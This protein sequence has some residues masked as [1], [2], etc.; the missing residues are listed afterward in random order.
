MKAKIKGKLNKITALLIVVLSMLSL[1]ACSF[2][3]NTGGVDDS[4]I[5][6]VYTENIIEAN[7]TVILELYDTNG[8]GMVTARASS[9]GSGVVFK[10]NKIA[11]NIK[12][13]YLLLTNNHVIY[14]DPDRFMHYKYSVRDCYGTVIEDATVIACDPNYDLAVV[15]FYSERE[16]PALE[17]ASVNPSLNSTVISM[18]QPLGVINS[19]TIGKVRGYT[20]VKLPTENGETNE[21]ISNVMFDVIMHSAPINNGSSGGALINSNYKIVGINYAAE[22]DKESEEFVA[23]YAV[24]LLKTLEFLRFYDLYEIEDPLI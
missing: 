10:K 19:V 22:I 4:K 5:N 1:S 11:G 16:Y 6:G 20:T 14:K 2:L 8:L 21:D 15:S 23:S 7:F 3:L 17:F 18:G 12:T 24:P 13:E 9:Q